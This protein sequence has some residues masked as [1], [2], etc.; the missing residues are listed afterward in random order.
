M[1]F[2]FKGI[3]KMNMFFK[4]NKTTQQLSETLTSKMSSSKRPAFSNEFLKQVK[5]LEINV[6]KLVSSLFAGEYK[7]SFKGQGMTFADFRQ[8]IPGD[9]IRHISWNLTAKAGKPYIKKYDEE[10]ELTMILVVDVSGSSDYGAG[11]HL[12]KDIMTQLSAMLALTAIKNKDCVGLLLFSNQVEHFLPPKKSRQHIYQ[13]LHD[14]LYFIPQQKGTHLSEV[15]EYLMNVLK[16]RSSLFIF[17]DFLDQNFEKS[18]SILAQK[19]D[20]V[21]VQVTDPTEINLPL[22]GLTH[23]QDPE[24]NQIMTVDTSDPIVR[25]QYQNKAID[26]QQKC[27]HNFKKANVDVIE[28]KSNQDLVAPLVN[29]FR[30]RKRK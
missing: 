20:V 13:I 9:D 7:T 30:R 1:L 4:K 22:I 12:K 15:F 11:P 10:R 24:T 17:S 28:I 6:K 21:A 23:I 18:L 26:R 16:K 2:T 3:N 5:L 14:I 27:L 19:H 8:Y 25:K 29:Y